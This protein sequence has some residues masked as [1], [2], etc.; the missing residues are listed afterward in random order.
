MSKI[1]LGIIISLVLALICPTFIPIFN[2]TDKEG[3]LYAISGIMFSIG[4]SLIVTSSFSRIKNN[5]TRN[6]F[7]KAYLSVRNCYIAEF[8]IVSFLYVINPK[9]NTE[10]S[11]GEI[12][13]F[14]IASFINFAILYSI[15][16]FMVNFIELQNL[17]SKLDEEIYR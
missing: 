6:K 12:C 14:S 10:I 2:W 11:L 16:F 13:K 7:K 3:T 8:L 5:N 1:I 17:N 15:I 9:S 4:M